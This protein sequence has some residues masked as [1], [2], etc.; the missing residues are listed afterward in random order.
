[1]R[2]KAAYSF[3]AD[4]GAIVLVELDGEPDGIEAAVLACGAVC[5]AEGARDVI[6]ARDDA[7]R[8]RL[9]KTRRVCSVA[10]REAYKFKLSE[11][12]VVPPARSPRCSGASTRSARATIWRRPRSATRATATCTSTCCRRRPGATP[13]SRRASTRRWPSCSRRTLDLGGTLSGEHGIGIA[14][15]RYMAWEQSAEVI[16]WQK[17]LKRLWDPGNL[18]NPGKI[19]ADE[20]ARGRRPA[21]RYL[22]SIL[23][24]SLRRSI[25]DWHCALMLARISLLSPSRMFV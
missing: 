22:T 17:R 3:P 21:T 7:D 1:M 24:S 23:S 11:D 9:W 16:D 19:F 18:L 25:F 13:R 12:T 10:L 14:K 2:P 5:E 15:A 4:A 8:E 20:R 6:I